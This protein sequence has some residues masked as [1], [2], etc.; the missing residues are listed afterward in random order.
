MALG[1]FLRFFTKIEDK[2]LV[3]IRCG[4]VLFKIARTGLSKSEMELKLFFKI[5]ESLA[6]PGLLEQCLLRKACQLAKEYRGAKK[7]PTLVSSAEFRSECKR[8]FDKGDIAWVVALHALLACG[9]RRRD[10][11][12]VDS[13]RITKVGASSYFITVPYDKKNAHPV[14]FRLD[15][16]DIPESWAFMPTDSLVSFIDNLSESHSKPF[17]MLN[18]SSASRFIG[19]RCHSLRNVKT[20][21]L[22]L[23]DKTDTQ[24]MDYIGWRDPRSVGRYRVL[25]RAEV[26]LL[27]SLDRVVEKINERAVRV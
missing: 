12:R 9:R 3:S 24:I 11:S 14:S 23:N 19:F 15:F 22:T 27:G 20:L 18:S 17:T 7:P 21:Q 5:V 8:L 26:V 16:A 10:L 25:T 13:S 1:R 4:L 6:S 2:G